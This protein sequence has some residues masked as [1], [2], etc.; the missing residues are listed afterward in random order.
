MG[1]CFLPPAGMF[2]MSAMMNVP[3]GYQLSVAGCPTR[4]RVL[5][6]FAI[7]WRKGGRHHCSN[8]IIC[9]IMGWETPR[10][11]PGAPSFRHPLAKGWETSVSESL[12]PRDHA[13]CGCPILSPSFGE[14]VGDISA[15]NTFIRAI[16]SSP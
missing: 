4:M 3:V 1:A 15:S 6:P 7:L 12:H 10:Q 9:E 8:P 13:G 2:F 11:V 14:T 16:T 5:H